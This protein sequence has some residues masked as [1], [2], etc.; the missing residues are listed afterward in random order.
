M[1]SQPW[2]ECWPNMTAQEKE[3]LKQIVMSTFRGVLR[4]YRFFFYHF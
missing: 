2:H 4:K 3:K 1:V